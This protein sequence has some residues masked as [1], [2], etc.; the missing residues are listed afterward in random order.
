MDDYSASTTEMRTQ[1]TPGNHA[2]AESQPTALSGELER[3]RFVLARIRG[4][5][6]W[7]EDTHDI[8]RMEMFS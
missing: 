3:L 1:T 7:Y 6:Y 4:T 2:G 5:Q 8:V